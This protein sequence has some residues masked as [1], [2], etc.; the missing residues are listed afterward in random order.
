VQDN[1]FTLFE[2]QAAAAPDR[3][4][5]IDGAGAVTYGALRARA[6]AISH[7]LTERGL[8]PEQPVGVLMGRRTQLLAALLGIMRAGGAYVPFDPDDPAARVRAMM[9]SSGSRLVIGDAALIAQM[10]E[11]GPDG[12]SDGGAL[13]CIGVDDIPDL[14]QG[15][16][17]AATAPGGDRLA[18]LLFT[19]GSTGAPKAVE[20]EHR[21][22]LHLLASV[23]PL[24]GFTAQD[25]YLASST[26]AFDGSITEMFLPLV[27]G[28]SML[29][30][31]RDRLLEP[32][33]LARD[34]AEFGVTMIQTGPSVW[35]TLL[36]RMPDFPRIRVAITHGEAAGD[37]I[38]RRLCDHA[39]E[40]WNLYG[41]TEATVW[42]TG[43]RLLAEDFAAPSAH[44]APIGRPLAHAHVHVVG[45]DGREVADG[46][47]GELWLGGPGVARGYRGNPALTE[48]RFTTL[49]GARVYRSG[50][51]AIRRADGVVLYLGRI[52]DQ[53]Q[54][55]GV[56]V[57][58]GEV[59]QAIEADPRVAQAAV[60]W[61]PARSGARA[62]VAAV[63]LKPG[64]TARAQDIHEALA[65]RL[66]RPMIPSRFLFVPWLPMTPSGKVDRKVLRQ[67]VETAPEAEAAAP[68]P[69]IALSETER[70]L[71]DIWRR[72]LGLGAV[73]PQDHF[74]SIGGDSLSAVQM[75]IEVES[76]FALT[77]PVHLAFEAPTLGALARRVDAALAQ[78][79]QVN[80]KGYVFHLAG[81]GDET[82]I[83]FSNIDL[84]LA[85][86]G[87]WTPP[88]PVYALAYWAK[89]SGLLKASSIEAL[90]AA[91]LAK[92]TEFQPKG[93]YR[94]GGYSLGG[95]IAYE[96]AQQLKLAGEEVDL[97]FLLDPT[98]PLQASVEAATGRIA[99]MRARRPLRDR[100]RNRMQAL[101]EGPRVHGWAGLAAKLMPAPPVIGEKMQLAAWIHYTLVNWH[102]KNPNRATQLLLPK[103]RW[104]AFWYSARR[105][106]GDYV[107]DPYDGRVIM[108]LCEG[109][110][111]S[112]DIYK[113]LIGQ[114]VEISS[115]PTDHLNLFKRPALDDWMDVLG[116]A[117]LNR[118]RTPS[119]PKHSKV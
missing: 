20:V 87:M 85:R 57:E 83:F 4:A 54:I 108:V 18:Y 67:A 114:G 31:D 5:A 118:P 39:D 36:S 23:G 116:E 113:A 40:A 76:V 44:G 34:V 30:R 88:L 75:I 50:D 45:A 111:A 77:L 112:G 6:E 70:V 1:I 94:L 28:A 13:E 110:G 7:F 97:L 51:L 21:N 117:V 106:I 38:A 11:G 56:R 49:D 25:R 98:P 86:R 89:G 47:E 80:D 2:R 61:F 74:F 37:D 107:A 93:P 15:E 17:L 101:A 92:I 91:H 35:A 12:G 73:G 62:I 19:S 100:L 48:E 8:A 26:I 103:N 42:A 99:E 115:I 32:A 58:P 16:L 24:L 96:M 46:E 63:V 41:P 55:R 78:K 68:E 66:P 64:A 104:R 9:A 84:S 14:T 33:L 95:L 105:L 82:P 22:V 102:L 29:I 109:N 27:T 59:E 71:A 72:A 3:I 60:T 65:A 10:R 43:Q 52:D 119:A 69:A 90:A 53:M 81:D 79:Q